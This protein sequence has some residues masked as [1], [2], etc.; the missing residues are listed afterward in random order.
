MR[1]ETE[2]IIDTH[3]FLGKSRFFGV[4]NSTYPYFKEQ[5]FK[6]LHFLVIPFRA[7]SNFGVLKKVSRDPKFLGMYVVFNPNEESPLRTASDSIGKIGSLFEW[8]SVV[9]LKSHPS[10]FQI[11][12]SDER[13]FPYYK[14]AQKQKL[15]VLLHAASSGQDYN[16]AEMTREVLERFPRLKII[17]AHFGGLNPKYMEE[18][19]K[20][21][22]EFPNLILNTTTMDQIGRQRRVSNTT[23][24]RSTVEDLGDHELAAQRKDALQIFLAMCKSNPEQILFGSDLGYNPSE[25]YSFWPVDQA[26]PAVAHMILVDNPKSVFGHRMKSI[27]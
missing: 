8:E 17:L 16:S 23:F 12:M 20:L 14:A 18:A 9:G 27:K 11:R 3:A 24:K 21:A 26:D 2:G 22:Q 19:V 1:I 13:Y 6:N 4:P 5:E 10:F 15:P 25:D 7:T